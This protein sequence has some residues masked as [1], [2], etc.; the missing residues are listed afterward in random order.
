MFT[1]LAFV[2]TCVAIP[3]AWG[4]A[5]NWLFRFMKYRRRS[6]RDESVEKGIEP[7][8]VQPDDEPVIEYYI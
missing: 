7:P 8:T 3:I 4:V 1:K 6:G 5:V 2:L